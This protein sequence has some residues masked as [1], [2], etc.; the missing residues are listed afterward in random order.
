MIISPYIFLS[1]SGITFRLFT[2]AAFSIP[3]L[4]RPAP[5]LRRPYDRAG[6]SISA[7]ADV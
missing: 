7:C 3:N 6:M 4:V 1:L 2:Q 5:K